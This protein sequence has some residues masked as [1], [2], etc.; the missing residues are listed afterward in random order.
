MSR[1]PIAIFTIS[2]L[3]TLG[4]SPTATADFLKP[5]SASTVTIG[6]LQTPTAPPS[7]NPYS[8]GSCEL[9]PNGSRFEV[10][11]GF[12]FIEVMEDCVP[13]NGSASQVLLL[14]DIAIAPTSS[15]VVEPSGAFNSGLTL[16]GSGFTVSVD[17]S[18]LPDG[19]PLFEFR[20]EGNN[21]T[22]NEYLVRDI[23]FDLT[24]STLKGPLVYY[25]NNGFGLPTERLLHFKNVGFTL[26]NL[27][28][29]DDWASPRP[30]G[31]QDSG[32][33][34][35]VALF[36][37]YSD[38][39]GNGDAPNMTMFADRLRVKQA[40]TASSSWIPARQFS[41]ANRTADST[42]RFRVFEEAEQSNNQDQDEVLSRF[43][44]LDIELFPN[45]LDLSSNAHDSAGGVSASPIVTIKGSAFGTFLGQGQFE[46]FDSRFL[47][48]SPSAG[49]EVIA[50]HVSGILDQSFG[51][52]KSAIVGNSLE[53]YFSADKSLGG[54][55]ARMQPYDLGQ[56]DVTGYEIHDNFVTG[57]FEYNPTSAHNDRTT[58]PGFLFG[59]LTG[60]S[61]F[62]ILPSS[63]ENGQN[64]KFGASSNVVAANLKGTWGQSAAGVPMYPSPFFGYTVDPVS[65]T[66]SG[67]YVLDSHVQITEPTH[68]KITLP[69]TS[70]GTTEVP[71]RF[72]QLDSDLTP[73]GSFDNLR[74][75]IA[76][77]SVSPTEL[78]H[79]A[80]DWAAPGTTLGVPNLFKDST[81]ITVAEQQSDLVFDSPSQNWVSEGIFDSG[82]SSSIDTEGTKDWQSCSGGSALFNR[83]Q[84]SPC[85]VL[86][87]NYNSLGSNST[88]V[89]KG[90]S[91][92]LKFKDE[93][94]TTWDGPLNDSGNSS[95]VYGV[96][97]DLTFLYD[98]LQGRQ[99]FYT[100]DS[101]R[102]GASG[103]PL[104]AGVTLNPETGWITGATFEGGEFNVVIEALDSSSQVLA[105]TTV[106]MFFEPHQITFDLNQGDI[107]GSIQ[108][109]TEDFT[110]S[111]AFPVPNPPS[112]SEV[113]AGWNTSQDG[114]GDSFDPDTQTLEML[115]DATLYAQYEASYQLTFDAN[116]PAGE[117]L[118]SGQMPAAQTLSDG[119]NV[120][121]ASLP[122]NDA[123]EFVRD[124]YFFAGWG[125]AQDDVPADLPLT[126]FN[127]SADTVLYAIWDQGQIT[128]A[129]N[130][131]SQSAQTFAGGNSYEVVGNDVIGFTRDGFRFRE[132]QNA[133]DSSV[134]S[135]GTTFDLETGPVTL[136]AI[137][138]ELFTIQFD[139]GDPDGGQTAVSGSVDS[140][141]GISGEVLTAPG[142]NDLVAPGFA[143]DGWSSSPSASSVDFSPGDPITVT[144]DDTLYAVWS[145]A[146]DV[147]L[148]L[149]GGADDASA[150]S[151]NTITSKGGLTPQLPDGSG[152]S[153]PDH[154]ISGWIDRNGTSSTDDDTR[155]DLSATGFVMPN[156]DFTL[157]AEWSQHTACYYENDP[158]APVTASSVCGTADFTE[159]GAS[160]YQLAGADA[161]EIEGYNLA[162]W[163]TSPGVDN[164]V[165]YELGGVYDL[166]ADLGSGSEN[167][168]SFFAVW[169]EAPS[170]GFS[171]PT[172]FDG[173]VIT[174]DF[175][176]D[177]FTV[178]ENVTISGT[179]LDDI[180]S[181]RFGDTEASVTASEN[182]AS[183]VVPDVEPGP[184]TLTIESSNGSIG[185]QQQVTVL[186]SGEVV[187]GDE[188]DETKGWTSKLNVSEVKMYAKNIQIGSKYQFFVNGE[189]IAW[190]RKNSETDIEGSNLRQ[191]LGTD[192]MVRTVELMPGKN[193]LEVFIDGTRVWRAA[194][195][196]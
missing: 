5:L 125:D 168:R 130:G 142:K 43:V 92:T 140:I 171:A 108:P 193:A 78:G 8:P 53:G 16:N 50:D 190:V 12:D 120:S 28:I 83:V 106:Q 87:L 145:V 151:G 170:G 22:T 126:D 109:I 188:A 135:V 45:G 185:L 38:K 67:G 34:G 90:D 137:W 47:Y 97:D 189:E 4:L 111:L 123:G 180:S 127:I 6:S 3:L 131:A 51:S 187:I 154:Y 107:G 39:S 63:Q 166:V 181:V 72:Y 118:A 102:V 21:A 60:T 59:G 49:N 179:G 194:Y 31:S 46:I 134:V 52:S 69:A 35:G 55:S 132:W 160:D 76:V 95:Y 158:N 112:D 122:D 169:E 147:T 139:S 174:T 9:S 73:N 24:G 13:D 124:G 19:R 32:Q 165:E 44:N 82:D 115:G 99:S 159:R 37:Y 91:F 116:L 114:S 25:D 100:V 96:D 57:I 36:T 153:R 146:Q 161:F 10:S 191:A 177:S 101:F 70:G 119:T 62:D 155:Y 178:G 75:E 58:G 121:V 65:D 54:I 93:F 113:F 143:F 167:Q 71:L 98:Y 64:V 186:A 172:P 27:E 196:G 77:E 163:S 56:S 94:Q 88:P 85:E 7:S 136:N 86:T 150:P 192:Y 176:G 61:N 42:P 182:S 195:G 156:S 103:D 30:L 80:P 84:V 138:D 15:I 41:G 68:Q 1:R 40:A 74:G 20:G 89:D 152:F 133:G 144:T 184:Y 175:S 17:P 117:S 23:E 33:G 14:R 173:P 149:D 105:S 104:P 11:N 66:V 26:G 129:P 164:S 79:D 110:D 18:S 48:G 128:Y 148:T 157:F 162:G 183:F 29:A 141:E 2:S 81:S